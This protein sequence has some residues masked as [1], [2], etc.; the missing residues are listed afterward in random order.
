[1]RHSTLLVPA[2]LFFISVAAQDKQTGWKYNDPGNGGFEVVINKAETPPTMVPVPGGTFHLAGD[3]AKT[4]LHSFFAG[5]YEETNAQYRAYLTFLETYKAYHNYDSLLEKAMPDTTIW[6]NAPL[7]ADDRRWLAKNYLWDA[8]YSDYP[9]LGLSPQQAQAY[10]N[11]KTDRINELILIREGILDYTIIEPGMKAE[12]EPFETKRYLDGLISPYVGSVVQNIPSLNPQQETRGVR[13][14]D[15]ILMPGLRL[16][17][18]KEWI[19]VTDAQWTSR[20]K[21]NVWKPYKQRKF[22]EKKQMSYLFLQPK[23]WKPDA[24]Q[25]RLQNAGLVPVYT[26]KANAS[27]V[28]HIGDNAGEWLLGA[29][30]GSDRSSFFSGTYYSEKS[31]AWRVGGIRLGMDLLN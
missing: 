12:T 26:G 23:K 19:A 13:M 28:Y 21:V 15:G 8:V 3:T 20:G 1:M 4:M 25:L 29:G 6:N 11:W 9:V 27:G 17:T 14:E 31:S 2:C 24:L 7:P 5:R 18:D 16:L 22:D 30:K 10:A